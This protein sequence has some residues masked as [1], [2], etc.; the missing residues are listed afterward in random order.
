MQC[1]GGI[2]LELLGDGLCFGGAPHTYISDK[3]VAAMSG[4]EVSVEAG[5]ESMRLLGCD[6][7]LQ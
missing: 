7:G 1:S 3:C 4:R 2:Y 6:P 5:C